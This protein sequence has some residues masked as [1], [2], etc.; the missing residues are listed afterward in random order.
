MRYAVVIEEGE[1]SYGADVPDLPGCAAVGEAVDEVQRLIRE[2]I[3]F[4]VDGLR[5]EGLPIPAPKSR[6]EYIEA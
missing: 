2:A 5:E 1:T 3:E 6:V 4:H